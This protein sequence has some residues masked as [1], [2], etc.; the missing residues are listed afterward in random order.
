[1]SRY[2]GL[3]VVRTNGG[4]RGFAEL[5]GR[6][7]AFVP[8][9]SAG[10]LFIRALTAAAGSSPDRYFS[11]LARVPSHEEAAR[12]LD[13]GDVDA[14]AVKDLVLKRMFASSPGLKDR[15]LI[16]ETST[17]FPENALVVHPH[18]DGKQ[19]HDLTRALLSCDR[20][21]GGAEALAAVGA[22]RFVIT[23]D[24]DYAHMYSMARSV[25]YDFRK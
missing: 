1:V 13:R 12:M 3:V 21:P 2:R 16:L 19:R 24:E 25:G 20:Q 10:D 14:A 23:T 7:L 4:I 22:D 9:T 6:S 8:D 17:E 5:R 15:I 18:I 11:R